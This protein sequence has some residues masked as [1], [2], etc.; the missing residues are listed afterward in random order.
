MG[1]NLEK[2]FNPRLVGRNNS[3]SL[4]A[5]VAL[6]VIIVAIAKAMAATM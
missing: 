4:M 6:A 5:A 2:T 3:E 1:N